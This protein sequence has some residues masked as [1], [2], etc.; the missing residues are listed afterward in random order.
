MIEL[1]LPDVE[2]SVRLG[3]AVAAS[4]PAEAGGWM[5][6]LR[7]ELGA[8]KSTVAR[9]IL[10]ALGH[11]G[12]VPS[13]TYTLVEPYDL[14]GLKVY[15]IDLYRISDAVELQYL[16]FDELDSGLRLV[17]WPERVPALRDAADLDVSL[18]Y[19]GSARRVEIRALSGRAAAVL[20]SLE[21]SLRT[22]D[23]SSSQ[24]SA[25]V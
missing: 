11:S 13:P 20:R 19:A 9:S 3:K 5:L 17:E 10:S 12:P 1:E 14:P 4:L 2:S 15:H 6:L 23:R 25:Q 7:G 22:L 24:P 16:G 21:A 8:G 18:H